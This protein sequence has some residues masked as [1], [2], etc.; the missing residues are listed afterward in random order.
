VTRALVAILL[1]SAP[2]RFQDTGSRPVVRTRLLENATAIV[3]RAVVPPGTH[4]SMLSEGP[5]I[6]VNLKSGEVSFQA[7]GSARATTNDSGEAFEQIEIALKPSRPSAPAAPPTEAP[8]GITRTTL[9]DNA[10]ARIVRV[11]FAPGSREPVHAHPN[12][13]LT[14]QLTPGKYD[15]V[16]GSSRQS[17]DRPAGFTRFLPRDLSHA[18]VSTDSE[19]FELVSVSIK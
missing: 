6:V 2:I 18:Y 8:P 19:P 12:D 13:L 1:L 4:D 9:I 15:I 7:A 10:D 3:T 5:L 14:V 16:L 17:G 11:R